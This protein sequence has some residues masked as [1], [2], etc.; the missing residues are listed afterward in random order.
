[1]APTQKESL[2]DHVE[3]QPGNTLAGNMLNVELLHCASLSN[4]FV[5][6]FRQLLLVAELVVRDLALV[7]CVEGEILLVPQESLLGPGAQR[8]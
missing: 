1:M 2:S 8:S 5:Y 4:P 7:Q 6:R 3:Y